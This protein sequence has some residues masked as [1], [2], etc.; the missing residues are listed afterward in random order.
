MRDRSQQINRRSRNDRS[1]VPQ[2]IPEGTS[3]QFV[4]ETSRPRF[5]SR[6]HLNSHRETQSQQIIRQ[7]RRNPYRAPEHA[8]G[9]N[10]RRFY[11]QQNLDQTAPN[12]YGQTSR[13]S[14]SGS[15]SISSR[16][17]QSHI[18]NCD[19]FESKFIK[20]PLCAIE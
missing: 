10:L 18:M 13:S 12:F 8:Y 19:L 4:T 9:T 17:V 11:S 16:F 7:P 3:V 5:A 15:T 6:S 1:P 14:F 20:R 2:T